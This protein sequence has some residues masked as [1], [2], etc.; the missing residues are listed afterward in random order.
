M[1]SDK[2]KK[3]ITIIVSTVSH[4]K[5]MREFV[6]SQISQFMEVHLDCA[7]ETC[8][9]RDYKGLYQLAKLGE[10]DVFPGVTEAY[11]PSDYPELT[12]KTDHLTIEE[13][14][15]ILYRD[16]SLFLGLS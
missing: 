14:T 9:D 12:L 16:V 1:A 10:Y 8:V 4:K 2:N 7:P 13:C 15:S 11:E 5:T 6:R 3:G